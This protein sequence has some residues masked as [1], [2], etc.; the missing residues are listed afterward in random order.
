MILSSSRWKRG[1]PIV[2]FILSY[3]A[4][5][6]MNGNTSP[7]GTFSYAYNPATGG[8]GAASSL[9]SQITLPNSAWV[10]N[11]FDANGRMLGT[12]LT[13]SASNIDSSV[14]TYNVGNQRTTVTRTGE[15]TYDVIGQV[16]GDVAAE[17]TTNRMNEQLHYLFDPAGNLNYRTNNTLIENLAVWLVALRPNGEN[18]QF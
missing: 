11:T 18:Q 9:I 12:W 5:N 6:R 3:D 8:T 2:W 17:G 4:A 10:S 16:V 15:N 7:A 13:N 1:Q 14:Y